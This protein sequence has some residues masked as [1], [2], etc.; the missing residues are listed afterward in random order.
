MTP[1]SSF[2]TFI[3][4]PTGMTIHWSTSNSFLGNIL[5][6][7]GSTP[8]VFPA[9]PS[10]VSPDYKFQWNIWID[11]VGW[12]TFDHWLND[13][14]VSIDK[15]C[16]LE[17][18]EVRASCPINWYLW[19]RNAGWI[20]FWWDGVPVTYEKRSWSMSGSAWNSQ[21]WWIPLNGNSL[22]LWITPT[23]LI[24]NSLDIVSADSYATIATGSTN[25]KIDIPSRIVWLGFRPTV[26]ICPVGFPA[27]CKIYTYDTDLEMFSSIDLSIATI[28]TYIL[29]DPFGSRTEWT[30]RVYP[31]FVSLKSTISSSSHNL[32]WQFCSE[33]PNSSLCPDG[34]ILRTTR[35]TW[36][37][38]KSISLDPKRSDF[39][40]EYD[41]TLYLRDEYGNRISTTSDNK[42][43]VVYGLTTESTLDYNSVPF[44]SDQ[45]WADDILNQV[46][47]QAYALFVWWIQDITTH[48]LDYSSPYR[49]IWNESL[50]NS[51]SIKSYAPTSAWNNFILDNDVRVSDFEV[52][53]TWYGSWVTDL[54]SVIHTGNLIFTPLIEVKKIDDLSNIQMW[55]PTVFTW[56]I[57]KNDPNNYSKNAK[58]IHALSIWN[59]LLSTFQNF[60]A[61][62]P[63]NECVATTIIWGISNGY[64]GY[65][66]RQNISWRAST[67][68]FPYAEKHVY[69]TTPRRISTVSMLQDYVYDSIVTY[70]LWTHQIT[71]PSLKISEVS[72]S[73]S[74]VTANMVK[75]IG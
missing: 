9:S 70:G 11:A 1:G 45:F 23:R 49:H 28:Y 27:Y 66:N 73:S 15:S 48:L 17:P 42:K 39:S 64:S 74:G 32:L 4:N 2:A 58:I 29:T 43:N 5:F 57:S 50:A 14:F 44:L 12:G 36:S 46:G 30:I 10:R 55:R 41:L 3:P 62:S 65:C 75:I 26:E 67:I 22:S 34:S 8:W 38:I 16:I 72:W 6:S 53:V 63:A 20:K 35:T 68:M 24:N 51:L 47:W 40:D 33:N 21:I 61:T 13:Q 54:T 19:I 69:T 60:N 25:F 18:Y 59:N 7:Q 37:I 56:T 31:S 52:T 71:Y